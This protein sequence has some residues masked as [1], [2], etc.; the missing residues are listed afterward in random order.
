MAGR[1]T[2]STGPRVIYALLL[3][4][5]PLELARPDLSFLVVLA[6]CAFAFACHGWGRIAFALFYRGRAPL[7]AYIVA[8]GLVVLSF[9]GGILNAVGIASKPS[10]SLCAY[11]GIVL[12]GVFVV[13]GARSVKWRL[14]LAH[15]SIPDWLFILFIVG[16]GT[17]LAETLFP[18]LGFNFQDD[19]F[20][21]LPRSERMLTIG[22]LGGNPYE[23]LGLSDFGVQSFFQAML[24][25]WLPTDCAY[26]FDTVFCFSLGLCLLIEIGRETNC[27]K[28]STALAMIVYVTINPQIVN[29]S[30]VYSTVVLVLACLI[31]VR[32][33][34]G[35]VRGR[36]PSH[37]L[38][39]CSV[40]V[41]GAIA[42]LVA[43][44]LTSIFFLLPFCGI[45]FSFLLVK[46]SRAG[47]LVTI[48]SIGGALI[49][50]LAWL[51]TH[52]DKFAVTSWNLADSA[53][54]PALTLYPS[55]LEAF[56]NRPTLYGGTRAEYAIA[57]LVLAISLVAS[58]IKVFRRQEEFVHLLNIAAMVGGI[59]VYFGTAC[60]VNNE[61]ALRYSIPFLIALAPETLL[62][63]PSVVVFSGDGVFKGLF[64]KGFAAITIAAQLVLLSIFAGYGYE[65]LLR[66]VRLHTVVSF[67]ISEQLFALEAAALSN[68][69]RDYIRAIQSRAPSGS[70]IWAWVDTPFHLD[71]ALN[72]VWNFHHDWS[73]APW[74]VNAKSGDELRRSLATHHVEYILWQ[75]RSTFIPPVPILRSRLQEPDWLEVRTS[76]QNTLELELALLSFVTPFDVIYND[77][78]IVLI[79][80]KPLSR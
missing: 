64:Q 57:L 8:L 19:F 80:L 27:T 24:L 41:G 45:I 13:R 62:F 50:L 74:R 75:Y 55:I 5:D 15:E 67:P 58:T 71:F 33:L 17:L 7:H 69:R 35:G 61:A 18:T 2:L 76:Y 78:T 11:I 73:V 14:L 53:L 9:V 20:S 47:A 38:A 37:L 60:F 6:V 36:M 10:V 25:I 68:Q 1:R 46:E 12:S 48:V 43:I 21:Y 29:L 66:L 70:R 42:S 63:H 77:G 4:V 32:I 39:L 49:A 52:A 28:V 26:A 22:T 30:S 23:L 54:E 34:L 56:R 3:L 59:A 44:K 40:P 51:I 79:G 65:R 31:S 16:F 72:R